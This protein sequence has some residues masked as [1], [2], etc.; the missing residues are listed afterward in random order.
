M[1][2]LPSHTRACEFSVFVL[3]SVHTARG[4]ASFSKCEL[5]PVDKPSEELVL[6]ILTLRY[7]N[8]LSISPR[9]LARFY[10]AR[11]CLHEHGHVCLTGLARA[12]PAR[13]EGL[14]ASWLQLFTN[15]ALETRAAC[16]I[17]RDNLCKFH[18]LFFPIKSY[19]AASV[20]S[21]VFSLRRL[22]G[23][24]RWCRFVDMQLIKNITKEFV[25]RQ[26]TADKSVFF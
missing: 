22:P 18:N 26:G 8:T 2:C 7:W 15:F 19:L 14:P 23:A 13:R 3:V 4:W 24:C 25:E 12:R 20:S 21:R 10:Y 16:R 6:D 1:A 17:D 9:A 5:S 11:A